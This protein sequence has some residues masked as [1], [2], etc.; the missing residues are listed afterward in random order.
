MRR[1]FATHQGDMTNKSTV[2]V[3]KGKQG[4]QET[5]K[6]EAADANLADVSA[7]TYESPRFAYPERQTL[8]QYRIAHAA[9]M[10]EDYPE[11][12]ESDISKITEDTTYVAYFNAVNQRARDDMP[13]SEDMLKDLNEPNRRYIEQNYGHLIEPDEDDLPPW[14]LTGAVPGYGGKDENDPNVVHDLRTEID[15]MGLTREFDIAKVGD[16]YFGRI[17]ERQHSALYAAVTPGA[18]RFDLLHQP[19][20]MKARIDGDTGPYTD[21]MQTRENMKAFCD[22]YDK[23]ADEV[24]YDEETDN[25]RLYYPL[26]IARTGTD[27]GLNDG[28]A[29]F[30]GIEK[31]VADMKSRRAARAS[32]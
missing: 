6:D 5:Q 3:V 2:N 20:S 27:I 21:L 31:A 19:A 25:R 23:H 22:M 8:E 29:Y 1:R 28:G 11:L 18:Q 14:I 7:D 4:F 15:A 26:F 24:E 17:T 9:S 16:V 32:Q 12:L 13:L 10:L 30:D